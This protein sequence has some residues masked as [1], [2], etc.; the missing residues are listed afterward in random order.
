MLIDELAFKMN[1]AGTS[2]GRLVM[3]C[4]ILKQ[5]FQLCSA[6]VFMLTTHLTGT[7]LNYGMNTWET[8]KTP[9]WLHHTVYCSSGVA[10]RIF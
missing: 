2:D 7:F 10:P 6:S 5:C 1:E 9:V 8:R 3:L 4:L